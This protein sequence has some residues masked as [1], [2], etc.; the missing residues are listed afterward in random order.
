[1]TNGTNDDST[2]KGDELTI[3]TDQS[4][5]NY[6]KPAT[7]AQ[8]NVLLDFNLKTPKRQRKPITKILYKSVTANSKLSDSSNEENWPSAKKPI[9]RKAPVL[10]NYNQKSKVNVPLKVIQPSNQEYMEKI[11]AR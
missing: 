5:I 3:P 6:E 2:S 4:V 8:G 7:N 10:C 1:M 9:E 11:C